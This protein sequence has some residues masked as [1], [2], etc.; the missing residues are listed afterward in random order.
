MAK[1]SLLFF[2]E[3]VKIA[4]LEAGRHETHFSMPYDTDGFEPLDD[5]KILL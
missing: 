3:N 2:N 1:S 5:E 4:K